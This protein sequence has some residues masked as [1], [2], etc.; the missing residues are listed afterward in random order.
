MAAAH[1]YVPLSKYAANDIREQEDAMRVNAA[2]TYDRSGRGGTPS[3]QRRAMVEAGPRLLARRPT[4]GH[5]LQTQAKPATGLTR[6][7]YA[8]CQAAIATAV[9]SEPLP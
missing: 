8:R 6:K 5:V 4:A 3:S 2:G 7:A 1:Q 9:L